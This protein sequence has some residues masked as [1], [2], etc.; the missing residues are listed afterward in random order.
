MKVVAL[1]LCCFLVAQANVLKSEHHKEFENWVD[2]YGKTYRNEVEREFR[3]KIFVETLMKINKHNREYDAGL[4]TFKAGLNK[5]SDMLQSEVFPDL[6]VPSEPRKKLSTAPKIQGKSVPDSFDWRPKGAVTKIK[7]QENCGSCWAFSVTGT[8]EGQ[9]FLKTGELVQLS[10]KQLMDCSW[11]YGNKGCSGGWMY[12]GY[13]YIMDQGGLD[14]EY[15]YPYHPFDGNKCLYDPA[16]SALVEKDYVELPQGDEEALK[17]AVATIGPISVSINAN[18]DFQ[19]YL[20]GVMTSEGCGEPTNH[21]VLV[22]GYGTEDGL[23]YW[24]VKNSWGKYY[25]ED[26]YIKMRRNYNNMC[27]IADWGTYPILE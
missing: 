18:W 20:E 6:D 16:N 5:Y 26:G 10:E 1:L 13:E 14:T 4:K 27:A 15:S 7:D 11:D 25:G 21:G 3:F 8:L 2:K 12:K 17:E 9:L 19:N 24:L 22:V 23:D